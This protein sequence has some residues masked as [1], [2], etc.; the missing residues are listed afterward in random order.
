MF[1]HSPR[2]IRGMYERTLGC[3]GRSMAEHLM[4]EANAASS[5]HPN[6]RACFVAS[7]EANPN[8]SETAK[9]FY[10]ECATPMASR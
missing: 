6:K 7:I 10:I 9:A 3:D 1:N 5:M 4:D 8:L 2:T